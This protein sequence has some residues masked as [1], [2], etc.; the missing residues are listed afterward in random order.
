MKKPYY[1]LAGLL[2]LLYWRHH[3]GAAADGTSRVAEAHPDD[4]SNP[5]TN[6]WGLLNGKGQ[7]SPSFGNLLP[8]PNADGGGH[9]AQTLKLNAG[10]DGS[11]T[12]PAP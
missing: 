10:W 6:M 9:T 2:A 4:G 3:Q 8:G 12:T 7:S 1:F 5:L 11:L